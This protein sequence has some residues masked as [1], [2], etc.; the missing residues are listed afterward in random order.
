MQMSYEFINS[1]LA[2]VKT[3]KRVDEFAGKSV[4][5]DKFF[6]VDRGDLLVKIFKSQNSITTV[7]KVKEG[8]PA[9]RGEPPHRRCLSP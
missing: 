4:V 8:E 7:K 2:G 5:Y 6:N 1:L 9:P 3:Y